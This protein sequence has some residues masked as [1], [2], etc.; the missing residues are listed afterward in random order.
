MKKLLSVLLLLS[1][2]L[3]PVLGNADETWST[4]RQ[5]YQSE[6]KVYIT[7]N[8]AGERLFIRVDCS[9]ET[10]GVGTRVAESGSFLS[11]FLT[12]DTWF[13]PGINCDDETGATVTSKAVINAV[14]SLPGPVWNRFQRYT[15]GAQGFQS[16][17]LV[18]LGYTDTGVIGK[19]DVFAEGET[20]GIG[21]RSGYNMQFLNQFIGKVPPFV[22]GENCDV[23]SGATITSNA[24]IEFINRMLPPEQTAE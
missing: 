4:G 5:G 21:A 6:V 2:L 23:I 20:E 17:V 15:T 19:I 18:R 3:T 1:M 12:D 24:V 11:Q 13:V 16:E 22:A 14:N 10:D 8:E 9:G 7:Y